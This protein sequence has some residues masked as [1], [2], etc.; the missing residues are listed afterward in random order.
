VDFG[1]GGGGGGG[2]APL[3]L[4]S[5]APKQHACPL[6][7]PSIQ[8]KSRPT[9]NTLNH[10]SLP[11]QPL[12]PDPIHRKLTKHNRQMRQKEHKIYAIALPLQNRHRHLRSGSLVVYAFC[13]GYS[14]RMKAVAGIVG[15]IV[16]SVVVICSSSSR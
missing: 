12:P 3:H 15:Y 7:P 6:P 5:C 16:V 2:G 14:A 10:P 1:G 8:P 11:L 13:R 4:P 9:S